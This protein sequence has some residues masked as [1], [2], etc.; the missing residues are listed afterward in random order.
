MSVKISLLRN[1]GAGL[2]GKV[3]V[4]LVQLVQVPLL[5]SILG[6]EDYGRWVVLYS[7]P[8]WLILANL[9]FGSVASTEMTIAVAGGDFQKASRL[10]STTLVMLVGLCV[11]LVLFAIVLVPFVPWENFLHAPAERHREFLY[12][13]IWLVI[14]VGIS[15][16]GEL[17]GGRFKAARKAHIAILLSSLKPWLDL[18]SLYVAVR[19]IPR[20]DYM[21]FFVLC[22]SI[23]YLL[24]IQWLSYRTL[25]R[26]HFTLRDIEKKSFKKLLKKGLAFQAF[27]LGNAFLFQGSILIVQS[28]LGPVAVALF[29]TVRT[30][31]RTISQGMELINQTVWPELSHLFGLGEKTKVIRLHRTAVIMAMII[32]SVGVMGLAILGPLLY[33]FWVGN[34]IELPDHLLYLFL[35]S[36]PLNALWVTSSVVHLASNQHEGLAKRFLIA[37]FVS[38]VSCICLSYLQGIEGA[39]ISTLTADIILIPYVLDKSLKITGDT[40]D[41]IVKGSITELR[42]MPITIRKLLGTHV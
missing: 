25:P 37:S 26:L 14:T 33:R 38:L 1:A 19:F 7:L 10:F 28:M 6:I 39:V 24:I 41:G 11:G 23:I 30:M 32:A 9:G 36:I 22:S 40:W 12:A 16:T 21:A 4:L 5:I 18:G 3:S 35:I 42:T 27:P 29:S 31:V 20:F 13:V 2:W 8:S 17:F 15:F 34:S